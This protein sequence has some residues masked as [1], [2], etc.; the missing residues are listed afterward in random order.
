MALQAAGRGIRC[1]TDRS[2]VV[3]FDYRFDS[4]DLFSKDN[5]FYSNNWKMFVEKLIDF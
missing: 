1:P 4:Y 3:M 5:I 2:T